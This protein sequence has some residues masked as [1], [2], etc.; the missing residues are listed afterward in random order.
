MKNFFL[1]APCAVVPEFFCYLDSP[2]EVAGGSFDSNLSPPHL[3][4]YLFMIFI[5]VMAINDKTLITHSI[6]LF[7]KN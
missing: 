1:S 2:Q 6:N 5:I 7:L 3:G 4:P